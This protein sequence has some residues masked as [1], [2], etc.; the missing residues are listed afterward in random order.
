[1]KFKLMLTL[2]LSGL[3]ALANAASS[4]PNAAKPQQQR[5]FHA[6]EFETIRMM[7]RQIGWAQ[8]A[9]A[10]FL[11][12]DWV[13]ND[14]AIWRT[15]DA[16]KSW[17]QVLSASPAE[18][19]NIS[20]FFR[21]S[22]T[23][24]VAVADESTNV[25]IFRTSN[26]GVSWSRSQLRQSQ[27]IQDSCLSFVGTDQGWLMLIPCH[28]MNSSPGYLYRTDDG[29]AHWQRV[30]STESNSH[31]WI[32]EDAVLPEFGEPHSYLVC[33]GAIAFRND[34]TGWIHGSLASTTPS[35][36]FITRDSGLTWQVQRLSLPAS[37]QL[38]RMEAVGLPRFFQPDRKEGN[39]L[40]EYHPTNSESTS[41]GTVIYRT[42]DG[43]RSWQPTTPV[44][45]RGV[46]S[47]ITARKG[48]IW[49]YE[50]HSTTSTAPVKGT[51]FRT[52]N[53]G[54]SWKPAGT[55]KTLEQYLVHGEDIVQLDFVDGGYGWAIAR[56]AHNLTQLLHTHDGGETWSAIQTK[57]QP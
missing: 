31:G 49:S 12:N 7:D 45:F 44:K 4:T 25:A 47:F 54:D 29:S 37:L 14:K 8:N 17:T 18:T 30:N 50:P 57:V 15:T 3:L 39:L 56:D 28:G 13:F 16:G 21:D 20:A 23:A 36:L 11:T 34:S 19:G 10:L 38:G 55:G 32:W 9:R 33:G 22:M 48:W 41:F 53:A 40:A 5:S 6:L 52:E 46:W 1:M 43:G 35:F 27:C 42:Q 24:W 26:G 2:V 51:L